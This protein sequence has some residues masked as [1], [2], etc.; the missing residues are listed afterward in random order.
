MLRKVRMAADY[1][2]AMF[3]DNLHFRVL[4]GLTE[5]PEA[6]DIEAMID[7]KVA[8]FLKAVSRHG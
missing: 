5:A 4:L 6:K 8:F 1:F 7:R 2:M 3:R